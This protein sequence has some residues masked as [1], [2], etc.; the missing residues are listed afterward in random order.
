MKNELKDYLKK[1]TSKTSAPPKSNT[2]ESVGNSF[3]NGNF[4]TY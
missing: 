3:N 1:L 4:T 2:I